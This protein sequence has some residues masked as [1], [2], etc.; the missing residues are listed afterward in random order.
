M[1]TIFTQPVEANIAQAIG[2][3]LARFPE[4]AGE[5]YLEMARGVVM[6][7]AIQRA[8]ANNKSN[9]SRRERKY[10]QPK[11]G[12]FTAKLL[13]ISE[14]INAGISAPHIAPLNPSELG[15]HGIYASALQLRLAGLSHRE[16]GQAL[17]I[18]SKEAGR[19]LSEIFSQI[20][21]ELS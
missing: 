20:R 1:Q 10:F 2:E 14:A 13:P 16:I 7:R 6:G 8:S 18:T 17:D 19:I 9:L 4:I 3:N 11:E 12:E 15:L 21:Q 5:T